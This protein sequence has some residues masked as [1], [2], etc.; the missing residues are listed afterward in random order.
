MHYYVYCLNRVSHHD[1]NSQV[2]VSDVAAD[3]AGEFFMVNVAVAVDV[4]LVEHLNGFLS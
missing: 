2:V 1:T 3:H 4:G